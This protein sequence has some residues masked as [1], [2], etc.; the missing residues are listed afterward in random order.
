[1][2]IGSSWWSIQCSLLTMNNSQVNALSKRLFLKKLFK[3]CVSLVTIQMPSGCWSVLWTNKSEKWSATIFCTEAP[4]QDKAC[5]KDQ[6]RK[7]SVYMEISR[8][9]DQF[10]KHDLI[11][12]RKE[13]LQLQ[14]I[15]QLSFSKVI[16]FSQPSTYK[17]DNQNPLLTK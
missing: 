14:I 11:I 16:H 10:G 9:S 17:L 4:K 13:A 6:K 15:L 12:T 1:M 3:Y 7:E 5:D 8:D 2:H